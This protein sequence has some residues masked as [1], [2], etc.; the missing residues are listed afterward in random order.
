MI[1]AFSKHPLSLL[2]LLIFLKSKS[3]AMT[4]PA[5]IALGEHPE[6]VEAHGWRMRL[7]K[8]PILSSAEADEWSHALGLQS[9]PE[10]VFGTNALTLEH[11]ASGTVIAFRTRDALAEVSRVGDAQQKVLVDA[12]PA[13]KERLERDAVAAGGAAKPP[14]TVGGNAAEPADGKDATST[15][16]AAAAAPTA[17]AASAAST[18][19]AAAS[20]ATATTAA[21]NPPHHRGDGDAAAHQPFRVTK[22]EYDYDWTFATE[23]AGTITARGG[24]PLAAVAS[25]TERIDIGA[26]MRHDPITHYGEVQ[27][28]EDELHDHGLCDLDIKIRVMPGLFFCLMR[29]WVRVDGVNIR[30]RDT[31]FFHR[32]GSPFVIREIKA[33]ED[34]V[35]AL[36]K[37]PCGAGQSVIFFFF[38]YFFFFFFFIFPF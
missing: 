34:T 10:M 30:V 25:D 2:F 38:F 6:G 7:T 9:M 29:F 19:T 31:R 12:A 24:A 8:G 17:S 22:V 1:A 14:L 18:A 32:F 26:L 5:T 35:E 3:N 27:L 21:H 33:M 11:V 13:W 16:G 4:T 37:V 20:S 15:P 28:F 36:Q 23:Y